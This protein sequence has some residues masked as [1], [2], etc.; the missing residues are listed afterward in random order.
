[1]SKYQIYASKKRSR[2]EKGGRAQERRKMDE[3]EFN[4]VQRLSYC[5]MQMRAFFPQLE[6]E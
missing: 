4:A 5:N 2:E 6:Q 1:M 3:E